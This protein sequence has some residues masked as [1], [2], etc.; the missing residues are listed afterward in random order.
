MPAGLYFVLKYIFL[1]LEQHLFMATQLFGPFNDV[2]TDLDCIFVYWC[3][4]CAGKKL[5]SHM[6]PDIKSTRVDF[7]F[8]NGIGPR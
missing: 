8:S 4:L 1:T 7:H 3:S 2:I 5:F 6:V